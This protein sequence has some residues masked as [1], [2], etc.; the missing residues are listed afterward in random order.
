MLYGGRLQEWLAQVTD[1]VKSVSCHHPGCGNLGQPGP[2][3][4]HL[5]GREIPRVNRQI[6]VSPSIA[7]SRA[8]IS[9]SVPGRAGNK[10]LVSKPTRPAAHNTV[11]LEPP[12]LLPSARGGLGA[13]SRDPAWLTV[14]GVG[15]FWLPVASWSS[16]G[17][18]P[19]SAGDS[20]GAP[21]VLLQGDRHLPTHLPVPAPSLAAATTPAPTASP[22]PL[23]PR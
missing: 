23:R 13:G 2:Q 5:C 9:Q 6:L 16:L 15:P 1:E 12:Q 18:L 17:H 19:V 21:E 3:F 7:R 14:G 8:A 4:P 22:T 11:P 10:S 20:R